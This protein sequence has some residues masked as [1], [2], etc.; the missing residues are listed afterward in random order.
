MQTG[1]EEAACALWTRLLMFSAAL[2]R[3]D[4]L[5]TPSCLPC[6]FCFCL[7]Q[8]GCVTTLCCAVRTAARATTISGATVPPASRASCARELA[9]RAPG[10]AM[11]NCLDGPPSIIP[12][13]AASSLS[14]SQCSLYWL[15]PFAER[16]GR[17]PILNQNPKTTHVETELSTLR[18]WRTKAVWTMC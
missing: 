3:S 2:S 17:P 9:A 13:S 16:P 12:P 4:L 1:H 8:L 15:F 5:I 10:S 18:T 7:P 11:T 14:P 6:P